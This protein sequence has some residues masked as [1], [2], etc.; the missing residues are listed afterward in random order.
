MQNDDFT[1]VAVDMGAGS[2]RIMLGVMSE[3][4]ISYLEIHRFKNEIVF[5]EGKERWD[6][7]RIENELMAGIRMAFDRSGDAVTSIGVDSW[8]VDFVLLDQSG[9]LLEAPVA[10]RDKRTEGM[11]DIWRT[12][13]PDLETFRRTGINFYL[14]NTLFQ[15]LSM[16][17]SQALKSASTL[18]F[19]PCYINYLLSGVAKNELTIASTS[20][21]LSVTGTSWDKDIT[22]KLG[23]VKDILGDIIL[24]GT[25]L[26]PVAS[27][28]AGN[29]KVENVAVCGHDTAAVVAAIPVENPNFAYISAGTWCVVGIESD[30]ALLSQEAME[31]GFT[32]ERGFGNSYR[33]LKNIV[34]LWLLQGLKNSLPEQTTF[35]DMEKMAVL[36]QETGHVIDPDAP[37]FYNPQSMKEVF[38]QYFTTTNQTFPDNFSAYIRC[39]YDSLCFSFR[40]HIE[41]LEELSGLSIEVLHMVGGGSQSEILNQRV[42]DICCRK[43]VSGPVEGATLGNILVQAMAMGRIGGLDEGRKLIRQSFPGK[44]YIPAKLSEASRKKYERY[45]SFKHSKN[46]QKNN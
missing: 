44:Q 36:G 5:L 11:H 24:P 26:G 25:R 45:L 16:K 27:G 32:N 46:K 22:S 7:E 17:D 40:Y 12:L 21:L 1:C 14:F 39:A 6:L 30:Q 38:D 29:L 4:K 3:G 15:L 20:Q 10:Y 43:V 18:L 28:L 37:A 31:L 42:A 34:G 41:K 2:I 35:D 13:M 8:G 19:M 9:T 23:V 33:I